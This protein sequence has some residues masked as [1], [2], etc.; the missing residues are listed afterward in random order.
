MKRLAEYLEKT[1]TKFISIDPSDKRRIIV[2]SKYGQHSINSSSLCKTHNPTIETAIDKNSFFINKAIDVHGDK[3]DYSNIEYITSESKLNILCK[4]HGEFTQR[5]SHHLEGSGCPIC[6]REN[7]PVSNED[8]LTRVKL[9]F[10]NLEVLEDFKSVGSLI[11][12]KD[13]ND[14]LYRVPSKNLLNGASPTIRLAV[15]KNLAF[16]HKARS[17]HGDKYSYENSIYTLSM[18]NINILCR[19][20]G[21]FSQCAND[22][23][24]G[25]GCPKCANKLISTGMKLNPLGWNLRSWIDCANRSSNFDSYKV[26]IV[27]CHDKNEQ[28]IKI[29]RSFN[30]VYKRFHD[31]H[32][33]PYDYEVIKIIEGDPYHI[34]KLEAKLKRICKERKYLCLKKFCGM[35][36]CFTPDCLELLK[37]YINPNNENDNA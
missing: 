25:R 37:D 12:V 16:I 23:L 14:I 11:L 8:F 34:F 1:N 5:A 3:Y 2:E 35:H 13:E 30:T 20:H 24:R 36:E 33:F 31:K 17:I 4:T 27:S 28:F 9:R 10:P 22:H 21:M 7:V 32:K 29:G 19:E 26:Y 6:H 18:S 15:D